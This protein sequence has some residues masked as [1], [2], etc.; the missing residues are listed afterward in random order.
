[1]EIGALSHK[2]LSETINIRRILHKNPELSGNEKATSAFVE[3][4]LKDWGIP[5]KSFPNYGILGFIDGGKGE[6][7]TVA[8]RADMD[9]LA[10]NEKN[11]VDYR[12]VVKGVSHAC[13][14]DCHTASLLIAAKILNEIKKDLRGKVLFLFQPSEE[15]PP[16][17]AVDMI[18]YGVMDGVEAIFG[19]HMVTCLDVGQISLEAGSRMAASLRA[20]IDIEGRG[21]HG[22]VPHQSIDAIV[23]GS[24]AVM[25]L[26]TLVSRELPIHD[27]VA[28]TVGVFKGGDAFNVVADNVHM[29]ATIKFFNVELKEIIEKS[30]IRIVQQTAAAFRAKADVSVEGFCSPVYNDPLLSVVAAGSAKKLFG[31]KSVVTCLPWSASEDFAKYLEKAPGVFAF[32]GGRNERKKTSF[33]PHHP[34]FDIDE[35]ALEIAVAMYAQFAADFLSK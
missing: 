31:E 11:E 23:A 33:P 27:P 2:Y 34:E 30:I 3:K 15:S 17:G 10:I 28:I 18:K 1:M 19:L 26:Q 12:S 21:G 4:K 8:L 32:I 6:N 16:G 9:A 22:G 13:G 14:H 29:E 25:N 7:K 20:Y 24:A 35:D 5:F